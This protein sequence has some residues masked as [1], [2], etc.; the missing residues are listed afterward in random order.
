MG[1][2]VCCAHGGLCTRWVVNTVGCAHGGL[3]TRWVVH[4]VGCAHGVLCVVLCTRWVVCCVVHTVGVLCTRWVHMQEIAGLA[5]AIARLPTAQ[6]EAAVQFLAARHPTTVQPQ[7]VRACVR[8]HVWM[9]AVLVW[10]VP[11][12]CRGRTALQGAC[13][14]VRCAQVAEGGSS[15][16]ALVVRAAWYLV[17][18][19]VPGHALQGG[20]RVLTW[21]CGPRRP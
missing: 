14:L 4:T 12:R 13:W 21:C 17:C 20:S 9:M 19:A 3:C 6:L 10:V 18:H 15:G 11:W 5:T 16:A 7:P 8:V 1:S 2:L